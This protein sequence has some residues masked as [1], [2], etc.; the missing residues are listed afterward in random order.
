MELSG[1]KV[2]VEGDI[3]TPNA[4]KT[5]CRRYNHDEPFSDSIIIQIIKVDLT[6]LPDTNRWHV[7]A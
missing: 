3:L 7:S 2:V 4:I 6:K 1:K 5:M